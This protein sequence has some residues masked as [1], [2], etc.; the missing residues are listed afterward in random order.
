MTLFTCFTIDKKIVLLPPFFKKM[1]PS[2]FTLKSLLCL[3]FLAVG[4]SCFAQKADDIVGYYYSVDPFSK[5]GSQNYIYKAADGTYEGMV[6]WVSNPEKKKFLGYVFLKGL[7][8]NAEKKE[9]QNGELTYP[10]KKG[11]YK[12]YMSFEPDGKLK[13]RGYWGVSLLGKTVYW[14]REKKRRIQD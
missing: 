6:T 3:L 12:T 9:W 7:K 2:R 13:V 8:Y 14:P 5:E 11:T 1:K 4:F 10:G